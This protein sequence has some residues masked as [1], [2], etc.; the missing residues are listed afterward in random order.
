MGAGAGAGTGTGLPV[1]KV[2]AQLVPAA[3]DMGTDHC[4][5]AHRWKMASEIQLYSPSL[6][7]LP[8]LCVAGTG[9]G[10]AM[11]FEAKRTEMARVSF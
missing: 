7:Q 2:V 9:R 8:V 10:R 5:D 11:A 4:P 3:I 6:E 1:P